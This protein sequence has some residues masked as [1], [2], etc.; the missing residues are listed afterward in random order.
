MLFYVGSKGNMF[1]T[2]GQ[3]AQKIIDLKAF[4]PKFDN[5]TTKDK[6]EILECINEN[7][8]NIFQ[9]SFLSFLYE[10]SIYEDALILSKN[11]IVEL[12]RNLFLQYLNEEHSMRD[13]LECWRKISHEDRMS[14]DNG[15]AYEEIVPTADLQKK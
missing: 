6:E 10:K 13:V 8:I 3:I 11:E 9:L 2:F 15:A 5:Y 14:C 4:D 1:I 7:G 12:Q